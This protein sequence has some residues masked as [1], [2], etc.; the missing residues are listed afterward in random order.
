MELIERINKDVKQILSEKR[1]NHSVGVMKR[2]EEI[3]KI[4]GI[5]IEKA[6]L[7]GLSHDI[8]KE[9][10]VEESLR[11]VKENNIEIDEVERI[12]TSLL[13]G[14]IGADICRKRYGFNNQMTDAIIYHT[15]GNVNMDT[16]AKVIFLAD[17]TEESRGNYID[18]ETFNSA[19]DKDLDEGMICMLKQTIR[20]SLDKGGLVHPDSVFLL[21]KLIKENLEK[22]WIIEHNLI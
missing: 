17:K 9:M 22:Y 2:A 20:Y 14:K 13:H 16:F 3:A 10:N 18:L 7:V 21:N 6:R 19:I 15:T 11:Y 8:A 1:Y 12:N 4:Y 5:D